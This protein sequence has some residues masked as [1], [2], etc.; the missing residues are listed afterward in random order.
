MRR[1]WLRACFLIPLGCA[2]IGGARSEISTQSS[3]A[4]TTL[5]YIFGKT[6]DP[7]P[8]PSFGRVRPGAPASSLLNENG[9]LHGDKRPDLAFHQGSAPAVVWSYWDGSDFEIAYSEWTGAAWTQTLLLTDNVVDDLDPKIAI[10]ASGQ[11]VLAWWRSGQVPAVF[12]RRRSVAAIWE[13][14]SQV[15]PADQ[16]ARIPSVA[17]PSD[18]QVRISYEVN[19]GSTRQVVVTRDDRTSA[20]GPPRTRPRSSRRHL[21]PDRPAPKLRDAARA[22]CDLG[23]Q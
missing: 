8:W 1:G 5:L 20:E 12:S 7:D 22:P 11:P 10:D 21:T 17:V 9:D 19:L 14:E 13:P 4:G 18:G 23:P 15:S 6:S 3:A 2:P 16:H